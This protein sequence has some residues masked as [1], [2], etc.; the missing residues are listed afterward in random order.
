MSPERFKPVGQNPAFGQALYDDLIPPDHFLSKL[1]VLIPWSR[2]SP[3]LVQ[4]YRGRAQTGRPPY[5]P[6]VLL[7]MLLVAYLYNLSERQVEQSANFNLLSKSFLGLGVNE[8]APD[9]STLTAFKRRL[10]E[11]GQLEAFEGLLQE[12]ITLAQAQGIQCG[13][14][15]VI[16]S[17]HTVANVNVDK[18]EE[19]REKQGQPPR[20]PT[21]RWGVKHTRRVKDEAGQTMVISYPHCW[22][23]TWPRV[24]R[25]TL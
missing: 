20:D 14:I 10:L 6:V 15:Q 25:W 22:S 19:R 7:K 1:K 11:N 3:T 8:W 18:D 21:A 9:H 4:Y 17:V 5:D 2:F 16:D 13:A 12:I 24:C 23:V